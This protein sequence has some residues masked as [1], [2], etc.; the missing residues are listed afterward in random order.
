VSKEFDVVIAGGGMAGMAA[1]VTSARLGRSTVIL[2]GDVP[3]GQLMSIEK[4]EGLPGYPDGIPGYDLS[5]IMQDQAGAAGAEFMMCNLDALAPAYGKWRVT[6]AEG[7]I[8][9]GAV[10]L[11]TGSSLKKLGVPGEDRLTGSGVSHCATCDAPL[12]RGRIVAVVGGGDSAMQEALTLA[13][14][15]SKVIILQRDAGLTGQAWYRDRIAAHPKIE[16]RCNVIVREILGDAEVSGVRAQAADGGETSEIEVAAVFAYVGLAPNTVFLR[17][18]VALNAAGLIPTDAVS[19]TA[20]PGLCSAGNIRAQSSCRAV[21]AA[22]DGAAAAVAAHR[23]LADSTWNGGNASQPSEIL[24][25]A[26]IR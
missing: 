21:G 8:L 16:V 2:T 7:E 12:M 5:P 13:E 4:V 15:S 25:A 9:A 10:I 23:Y 14:F 6:T 26:A 20:L 24:L 17:N 11:A 18:V 22:G 19:R 3:G 1:G